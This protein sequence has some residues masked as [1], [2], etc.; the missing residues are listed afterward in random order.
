LGA[1]LNKAQTEAVLKHFEGQN[2]S[3]G[4]H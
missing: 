3:A 4:Q 2:Q 1:I